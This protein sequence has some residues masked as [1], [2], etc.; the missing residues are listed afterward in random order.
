MT[1]L[2]TQNEAGGSNLSNLIFLDIPSPDE[3]GTIVADSNVLSVLAIGNTAANAVAVGTST[4]STIEASSAS[5]NV[6]L[7]RSG[8]I[9]GVI[10][11]LASDATLPF[12]STNSAQSQTG[13]GISGGGS[14]PTKN[15]ATLTFTFTS[16]LT[17][18]EI[19][20]LTLAGF[21]NISGNSADFAGGS[22]LTPSGILTLTY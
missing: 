8:D 14:S 15:G 17:S 21:T 12:T 4:T 18:Q 19:A 10:G 1:L 5:A 2:A 11:V 13:S 20:A 16:T 9:D 22:T 3:P 7:I 6:Q